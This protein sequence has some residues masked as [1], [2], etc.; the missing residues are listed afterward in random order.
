M[1]TPETRERI[2]RTGENLTKL[3]LEKNRR[4]GNSAFVPMDVFSRHVG[5]YNSAISNLL[6]RLDDK[7]GRVRNSEALRKNDIAD[8]VG[9]LMLLCVSMGWED[10]DEFL[11]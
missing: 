6:V 11:D 8:L 3:L 4:Y 1:Q 5:S 2:E 7:L 10:F 9:Y